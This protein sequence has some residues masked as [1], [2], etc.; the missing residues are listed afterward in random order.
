VRLGVVVL[1]EQPWSEAAGIWR[2]AEGLGF[3]HAWTY[4][5]LAW[6]SLRDSAWFGAFPVLT[7][8][9]MVT[10]HIRLGTLVASPNFRHPVALAREVLAIDDISEGR[11]ELGVGAGGEGW[12]ATILG[13]QPWSRAE[14][15]ARFA[16]FVELADRLLTQR[17]LSYSGCYYQANEARSH[18]GC[19]QQPRVPFV[20]AG[21]GPRAM[22]VVAR[23]GQ[24][25]V[26]TGPRNAA[27]QLC[28][29]EGA[30][31]V[32]DQV[33]LLTE[34]CRATGRNPLELRRFVLAGPVLAQGL[35]SEQE[36]ADTLGR[37]AEVGVTDFV[38]HWP[39]SDEPYRG[40]RSH[41]ERVIASQVAQVNSA[42]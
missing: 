32:A 14:R 5:H 35:S 12:D 26:T 15:S 4:D 21:A 1:P 9:A 39:R 7:A 18:P 27:E 40:D 37:Y 22:E 38:V 28:A 17:E 31:A 25:W 33:V 11:F 24:A 42:T 23:F 8:A 20:V 30:K 16:E 41:F 36:L 6:R 29:P 3:A 10:S 2:D 13:Q 19:R 34:A